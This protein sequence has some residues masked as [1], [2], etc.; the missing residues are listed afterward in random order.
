MTDGDYR[1]LRSRIRLLAFSDPHADIE[2]MQEV[3]RLA[4]PDEAAAD[5]VVGAGDFAD[6]GQGADQAL[7]VLDALNCPLVMV[8]G[9]HDR[10]S[11]LQEYAAARPGVH[12]LHGDAVT[13]DGIH[14]VGIGAA[15]AR[16][17]PSCHSEWL[18]EDDARALLAPH[19]HADVLV[20]HTPPRGAV[21]IHPDGV[22]GGS[23]AIR[24]TL[25]RLQPALC[26][27]GHVHNAHRMQQ[28]IHHKQRS[29]LVHNLGPKAHLHHV[30]TMPGQR[31]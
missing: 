28:R 16:A 2:A 20:S 7:S 12:L 25:L 18:H 26:L 9:N 14:L 19:S 21:D 8:S 31:S 6:K 4:A 15:I 23:D 22:S 29:T 5:L 3:V 11:Y 17:E 27:C 24:D 30:S 1:D 10:L 13:I